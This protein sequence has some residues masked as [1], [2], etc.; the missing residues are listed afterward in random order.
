[1][2]IATAEQMRQLDRMAIEERGIPS[3]DLMERAAHAL[4]EA[5]L[6]LAGTRGPSWRG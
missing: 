1:M 2:Y 4:A 5:A 6:A 3:A